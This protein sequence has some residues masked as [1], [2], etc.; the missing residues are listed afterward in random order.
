MDVPELV[1][2]DCD[3][4]LVDSEAISNEV[5]AR[6]LSAVGLETSTAEALRDYKGLLLR[7]VVAQAEARL[8]APLPDGFIEAYERDRVTEFRR[9]LEPIAGASAVVRSLQ[10]A[11]VKVCVAT[12]G[13]L[14]KTELTLGLTGLRDLFGE[15]AVFSAYSVPRGKPHPD[16]FLH[17]AAV[18]RVAP[19]RCVV[20]EDTTIGVNAARSAEMRVLGY[21]ADA[22]EAA[23]RAAGAEILRSLADIPALIG[24]A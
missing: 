1:I 21:A 8:H 6:A 10:A 18:M 23:L 16:L 20:V 3:G 15:N 11:G 22:D 13:K 14:E 24:L 9:R 7:D 12:Q 19:D 5:L 2:F 4:V 17:A